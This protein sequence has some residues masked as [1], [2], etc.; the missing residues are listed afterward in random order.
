[1]KSPWTRWCVLLGMCAL[2]ACSRD[3]PFAPGRYS[4]SGHLHLVGYVVNADGKFIETRVLRHVS[5]IPVELLYGGE[6]VIGRTT[7]VDGIYRFDGLAPG[8]YVAR[9][10]VIGDIGGKT[11]PLTIAVSNVSAGDTLQVASLGDL[12]PVPNPFGGTTIV[13]FSVSDTT[14]IDVGIRDVVGNPVRKLLSLEVQP[15]RHVVYWDGNDQTG[16]PARDSLFWI[17]YVAGGDIRAQLL[18][19]QPPP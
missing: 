4:I 9:S 17:T 13:F 3:P 5:G 18:F 8:G 15:A 1:M 19:K 14:W 7:T 11:L 12:Y 2:A 16:H 6:T 10:R